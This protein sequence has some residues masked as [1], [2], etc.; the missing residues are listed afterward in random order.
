ML[1]NLQRD[2]GDVIE[3]YVVPDGFSEQP[4]IR[5]VEGGREILAMDCDGLR[6]AVI[7]SGRHST[8]MIGFR[9]DDSNIPKLRQRQ[10]IAIYERR[11]G[12]LVYRRMPAASII[13]KRVLRLE[14]QLAPFSKIDRVL[15]RHFHYAIR[16]VERFGHET[17]MQ[18]FH[19]NAVNSI[20][21][22]GRLLLRNYEEFLE[23]GFEV[24]ALI[25][26]PYQEMAERLFL[27]KRFGQM[28]P[29]LFGERDRMILAP[30]VQ[31]FQETDLTL[32]RSIDRALKTADE[33]VLRILA[34]P[35]TQQ[36][37]TTHPDQPVTRQNVTPAL[38]ALSRFAVIGLKAHPETFIDPLA[39]YLGLQARDLPVPSNHMVALRLA[40]L[41]RQLPRSE[42]LL[43]FDLILYHF[44]REAIM[45]H[46][47]VRPVADIGLDG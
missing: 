33:Q 39:E 42:R 9:L 30:A 34:A 17:A 7:E 18:A 27:F 44:V 24:V 35:L 8:G 45:R 32:S 22:S 46:H 3:G 4:G 10:D 16:Q 25:S 12:L 13:R 1:F 15:D 2:S 43:E 38:D 31:H 14:T 23:K 29:A 5:V 11:T 6:E 41:L 40:G 28:P 36:L 37:V 21:I 20:Y 19:L 47:E 26:D